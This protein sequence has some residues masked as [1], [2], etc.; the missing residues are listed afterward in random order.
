MGEW[1]AQKK[2]PFVDPTL[3]ISR[4]GNTVFMD[5][6]HYVPYGNALVANVVYRRLREAMLEQLKARRKT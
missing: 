5:Y 2:V 1:L 4:D 6:S 3:A